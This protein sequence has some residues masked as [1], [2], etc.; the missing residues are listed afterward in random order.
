[1]V[2]CFG[3]PL[4]CCCLENPMDGGAW[5]AA[6]HG[7]AEGWTWLS[8]FTS[9]SL[10]GQPP[11]LGP[12]AP[13]WHHLHLGW[14]P[15]WPGSQY[16]NENYW[17]WV[18]TGTLRLRGPQNSWVRWSYLL[19]W[20]VLGHHWYLIIVCWPFS[21]WMHFSNLGIVDNLAQIMLVVGAALC[22]VWCLSMSG[23]Y[24]IDAM[25]SSSCDSQKCL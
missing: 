13:A 25:A 3:N 17:V 12:P 5:W 19:C 10:Q 9:L 1:M 24:S 22:I 23:L 8:D 2:L 11:H 20:L 21:G 14:L 15:I 18:A 16:W 7:V 6:V 4:Q